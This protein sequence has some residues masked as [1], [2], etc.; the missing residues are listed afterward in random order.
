[1]IYY[2]TKLAYDRLHIKPSESLHYAA[3]HIY[4]QLDYINSL[5]QSESW[6]DIYEWYVEL[7]YLN[8]KKFLRVVHLSSKLTLFFD[9][10]DEAFMHGLGFRIRKELYTLFNDDTEMPE[11]LDS[12][13]TTSPLSFYSRIT[14]KKRLADYRM[15]NS[16]INSYHP[17]FLKLSQNSNYD[18]TELNKSINNEI[19]LNFNSQ[20]STTYNIFISQLRH[21]YGKSSKIVQHTTEVSE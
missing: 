8:K 16:A 4:P 14:D 9:N 7:F 3:D 2:A 19:N 18:T 5:K 1:M 17:L 10:I 6:S 20:Q 21:L 11:L 15:K 13:Y 12:F